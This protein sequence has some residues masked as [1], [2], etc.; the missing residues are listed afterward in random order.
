[1]ASPSHPSNKFHFDTSSLFEKV[2]STY[3]HTSTVMKEIAGQLLHLSPTL[4]SDSVVLDNAAGPGIVTGEILRL[5]QFKEGNYPTI[6]ATD[7]SAAMIRALE[8]RAVRESWPKDIVKSHVMDSMDLSTFPDN[9]FTHIYMAAAIHIIPE[10]LK[11]IAEIK[12]TLK[13]DGVALVTSF[14]KQG[15]IEVFQHVQQAIRPDSPIW[16]GP[17][18]EEW[19]KEEKLRA[20]IEGGGFE[21]NKVEIQRFGT[22][23]KGEEWSTPGSML[24]ME[25]LTKSVTNG[26]SEEETKRFEEKLKEDMASA[27]VRSK[28][29]EMNVFVAIARK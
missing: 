15:F 9:M 12:R 23:M 19:L 28:S 24:L 26:W 2:A 3:E 29:Y 7:N 22:W 27:T 16:K 21:G 6:H 1:M 11:A 25:A 5:P 14:E 17:L 18:P 13:P 10:P 20:V 8:A 4:A